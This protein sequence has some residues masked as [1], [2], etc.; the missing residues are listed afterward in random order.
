MFSTAIGKKT[1]SKFAQLFTAYQDSEKSVTKCSL[2]IYVVEKRSVN[3][4]INL[5]I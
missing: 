2:F 1:F 4:D 3:T 5:K